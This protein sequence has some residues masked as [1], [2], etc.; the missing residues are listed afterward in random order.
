VAAKLY[1][2]GQILCNIEVEMHVFVCVC[3]HVCCVMLCFY[4][5][6][7]EEKS[8]VRNF[9]LEREFLYW[10][11]YLFTFQMFPHPGSPSTILPIPP[12]GSSMR[13]FLPPHPPPF[14]PLLCSVPLHWGIKPPQDQG[15]S[16]P[17]MPDKAILCYICCWIHGSLHV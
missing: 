14:L 11:L 1:L 17:L 2:K 4:G 6:P 16:L 3:M 13:L 15:P 9:W 7:P 10:S 8:H 5:P 12:F